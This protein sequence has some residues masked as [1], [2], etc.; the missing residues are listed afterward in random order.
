M[1]KQTICLYGRLKEGD[2]V[3]AAPFSDYSCL[4]AAIDEEAG[5]EVTDIT[6]I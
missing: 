3:V 5:I 6:S 4:I 1:C 2:L